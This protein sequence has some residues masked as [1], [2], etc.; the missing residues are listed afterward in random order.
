MSNY[1][2][3]KTRLKPRAQTAKLCFVVWPLWHPTPLHSH[4]PCPVLPVFPVV[5][6][7][8]RCCRHF[9]IINQ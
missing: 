1:L 8:L 7:H 9:L 6:A 4:P 5:W 2:G 3:L